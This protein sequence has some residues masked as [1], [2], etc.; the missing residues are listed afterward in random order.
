MN[1]IARGRKSL[2]LIGGL[3]TCFIIGGCSAGNGFAAR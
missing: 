2:G 1:T 3:L